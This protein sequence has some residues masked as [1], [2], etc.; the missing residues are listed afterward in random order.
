MFIVCAITDTGILTMRN[1]RST[2]EEELMNLPGTGSP[3][4]N[5]SPTTSLDMEWD[6]E[7][8][9]AED[10]DTHNLIATVN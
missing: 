2:T 6:T 5:A 7:F 3:E 9:M 8:I 1:A 4:Q 10:I